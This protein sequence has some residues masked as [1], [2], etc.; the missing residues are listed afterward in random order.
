MKFKPHSNHPLVISYIKLNQTN[1]LLSYFSITII[2]KKKNLG[3]EVSHTKHHLQ[4]M[5]IKNNIKIKNVKMILAGLDLAINVTLV[6]EYPFYQNAKWSLFLICNLRNRRDWRHGCFQW[7]RRRRSHFHSFGIGVDLSRHR[8]FQ[9]GSQSHV[10]PSTF[11]PSVFVCFQSLSI[12]PERNPN[13]RS[14]TFSSSSLFPFQETASRSRF[15]GA[16]RLSWLT[17]AA[18]RTIACIYWSML[19]RPS[20]KQCL[21][22]SFPVGF[23]ELIPW[24]HFSHDAFLI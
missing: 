6:L 23:P 7:L 14:F 3:V 9:H 21:G 18:T 15:A 5:R 20:R 12:P 22:G 19:E 4:K 8:L 11:Q 2:I 13:Y 17:T 24:V 16:T 1:P 10:P